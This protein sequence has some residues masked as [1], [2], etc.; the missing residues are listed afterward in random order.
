[1]NTVHIGLVGDRNPQVAAHRAI[2]LALERAAADA[3]LELT[4]TWIHSATLALGP[5]DVVRPFH[6]LWC[7]PASPYACPAGVLAA[8][9]HAREAGV[10]FL[11]TCGGFQHALLECAEAL[12]GLPAPAHAETDPTAID[13]LIAPL[14]CSLVEARGT[15][16]LMPGSG[17]AAIYRM[18]ESVETYHCSYGLSERHAQHLATGA[19]RVAARDAEGQVRA[20][21]LEGHPFFVATLFQPERAA[22]EQRSHPLVAAFVAA[23]AEALRISPEARPWECSSGAAR[24]AADRP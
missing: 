21:E 15:I 7:V 5:A 13:P 20:V 6:G 19:L 17:L 18:T 23:A 2:P 24:G 10:P 22:L 9:R 16:R 11:G 3:A 8:I 4:W 1:M 12:W 14:A